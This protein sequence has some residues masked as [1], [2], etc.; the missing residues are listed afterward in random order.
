MNTDIPDTVHNQKNQA[1]PLIKPFLNFLAR[2]LTDHPEI[3]QYID[4]SYDFQLVAGMD[5]S[6]GDDIADT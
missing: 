4:M 5:I 1:D 6:P 2:E 3:I